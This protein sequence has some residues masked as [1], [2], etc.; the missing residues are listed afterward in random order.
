M[1]DGGVVFVHNMKRSI[2]DPV[3]PKDQVVPVRYMGVI[4]VQRSCEVFKTKL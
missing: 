2:P 1:G 3:Y 4:L